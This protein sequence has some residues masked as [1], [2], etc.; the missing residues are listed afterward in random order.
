GPSSSTIKRKHGKNNARLGKPKWYLDTSPSRNSNS[1]NN[2]GDSTTISSTKSTPII[3][4][5]AQKL[6]K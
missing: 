2:D 4:R 1:N 6:G 3:D 5:S